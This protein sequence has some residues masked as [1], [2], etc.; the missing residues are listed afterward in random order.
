MSHNGK[1]ITY[2]CG[3]SLHTQEK[4]S[5]ERHSNEHDAKHP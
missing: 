2:S 1:K 5:N 4:Y 3:L